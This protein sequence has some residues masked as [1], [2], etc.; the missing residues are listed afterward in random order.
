[1]QSYH[2]GVI[3]FIGQTYGHMQMISLHQH[4]QHKFMSINFDM[5]V[6]ITGDFK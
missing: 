6:F 3:T 4:Q 1:M 5:T 2:E